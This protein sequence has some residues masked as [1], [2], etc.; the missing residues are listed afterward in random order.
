MLRAMCLLLALLSVSVCL[1]VQ[2]QYVVTTIP[3]GTRP[4]YVAVNEKTNRIYVSN[5]GDDT[6]SVINGKTYT[7]VATIPVGK[8]PNGIAVN[9]ITNKIYVANLNSGTVS[10]IDG[11][12]FKVKTIRTASIPSKV[13]VN[14]VT[15]RVYVTLENFTGGLAVI[16]GKAGKL[17]T[18][19]PLPPFPLSLNVNA[20]NN[21]IY[22]ADFLCGCGQISVVDGLT[23]KLR[24]TLSVPG[25]SELDGVALNS[26][27]QVIYA[28]DEKSGFYV[29]NQK[30]G[31]VLGPLSD[32]SSPNEVAAIPK[33]SLAVE[34]DTGSNNA[35]FIDTSSMA[36]T[37][38]LP[39]G[40]FP[41]GVAVDSSKHRVYV[42]NRDDG[43]LSVISL[44]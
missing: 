11:F 6:V 16:D 32:L 15:N 29:V 41:T 31:Q 26:A 33:T 36:V 13:A 22:I 12:N 5:Q 35:V 44:N 7:V 23:N 8:A 43:T 14:S 34:P 20:T 10:V 18:T 30:T 27:Q 39:V 38:E 37:M 3:L 1:R 17:L 28:T 19:V 42:V 9:P 4:L 40:N 21:R 2:A 24:K 25:A